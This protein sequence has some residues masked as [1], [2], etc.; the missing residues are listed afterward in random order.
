MQRSEGRA[1]P[2]SLRVLPVAYSIGVIEYCESL[3]HISELLLM[4]QRFIP[5]S[6]LRSGIHLNLY[7]SITVDE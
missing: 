5:I 4:L 7:Q 6:S 2:L 1:E 3:A